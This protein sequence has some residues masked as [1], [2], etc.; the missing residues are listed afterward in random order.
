MWQEQYG[1]WVCGE[2]CGLGPCPFLSSCTEMKN[3]CRTWLLVLDK[4][5][6]FWALVMWPHCVSKPKVVNLLAR[7]YWASSESL[8][9]WQCSA[10]GS[11]TTKWGYLVSV[12]FLSF[13]KDPPALYLLHL[14]KV[15]PRVPWDLKKVI[16]IS[17]FLLKQ[18]TSV[19][20]NFKRKNIEKLL[21]VLWLKDHCI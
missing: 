2:E 8:M 18:H 20:I 19:E 3:V 9:L 21:I 16:F 15:P 5:S 12:A 7:M 4:A 17:Y 1:C 11:K 10:E 14:H 6:Y 13:L